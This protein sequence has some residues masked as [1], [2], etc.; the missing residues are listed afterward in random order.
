M[1]SISRQGWTLLIVLTVARAAYGLQLQSV[2]AVGPAIVDGLGVTYASLGTL[3]GAYT[4]LG[5][6]LALP[7][8]W[9]TERLGDR[10]I[11]L[12]GFALMVAG[13]LVMAVAPGFG[14]ALAGRVI[15]GAGGVL[16]GISLPTIIMNRIPAPALTMAMGTLLAGWPVGIG[17]GSAG[18]PLLGS[19]RTAMLATAAGC[20]LP[21]LAT[22]FVLGDAARRS[23]RTSRPTVA[24]L[25]PV[26]AAGLVWACI[27]AGYA[28]LL[29]FAAIF[30]VARG[31]SEDAAG[32]LVSLTAFATVPTGPIGGWLLGRRPISGITIGVTVSVIALALLPLNVWPAGLLVTIGVALATIGGPIV[33]LPASVLAP[34]HRAMGMSVFWLIFFVTMTI[35]PPLAGLAS[36]LSGAPGAPLIVAAA[37]T[38]L[39]LPF[40]AVYA[41]A[42]RQALHP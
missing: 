35:L 21:M 31:M 27:N 8:G 24:E 36:D 34:A 1:A 30:F 4:S 16:L 38:A 17:L 7:V 42:R 33:A 3:V 40:L 2:G 14:V 25:R 5:I 11:V 10:R 37:F 23:G 29:G 19:W 15:S 18:L 32:G 6:V 28:V 26:V 41:G 20:A 22:Y 9:L 39:A 13:S 12:G